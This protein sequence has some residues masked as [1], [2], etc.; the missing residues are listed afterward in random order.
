MPK[1]TRNEVDT[2]TDNPEIQNTQ[3]KQKTRSSEEEH[4]NGQKKK[5]HILK[6]IREDIHKVFGADKTMLNAKERT[7]NLFLTDDCS[8]NYSSRNVWVC[9]NKIFQR[10]QAKH[11]DN[12]I[13]GLYKKFQEISYDR[14]SSSIKLL[15][16]VGEI[17]PLKENIVDDFFIALCDSALFDK[18]GYGQRLKELYE[19]KVFSILEL[20]PSLPN[21][22]E[23]I[24]SE[25]PV[26]YTKAAMTYRSEVL[27]EYINTIN[28]RVEKPFYIKSIF[29]LKEKQT[30]SIV[31]A[32]IHDDFKT[33][34]HLYAF[35]ENPEKYYFILLAEKQTCVSSEITLT[36][37]VA[38]EEK[39]TANTASTPT[40]T[41]AEI[42]SPGSNMFTLYGFQQ[43]KA[44]PT[45][46]M[47]SSSFVRKEDAHLSGNN[48]LPS[49]QNTKNNMD[50][51]EDFYSWESFS[52]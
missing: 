18:L 7:A 12:P 10:Q 33:L 2:N 15:Y 34:E 1:R 32:D 8:Q 30:V 23:L 45:P 25:E 19:N 9:I 26:P 35:L 48:Y 17:I 39:A 3:K 5:N 47:L 27:S 40:S 50:F 38:V 31:Y 20:S 16:R 37:V 52:F 43:E 46:Y 24:F 29:Y 36:Q 28:A 13:G 42:S 21:V 22:G 11:E 4:Q 41:S 49:A 44:S 14:E 6:D 51:Y